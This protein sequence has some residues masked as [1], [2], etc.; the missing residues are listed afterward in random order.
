MKIS[1][2]LSLKCNLGNY[3]VADFFVSVEEDNTNDGTGRS[4]DQFGQSLHEFCKQQLTKDVN[5]SKKYLQD[6]AN[7]KNYDINPKNNDVTVV[8]NELPE[9]LRTK[10]KP[11]FNAINSINQAQEFVASEINKLYTDPASEFADGTWD[12]PETRRNDKK[13]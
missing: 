11:N 4:L 1:K 12:V 10:F 3:Q 5:N 13:V 2:S 6:L 8:F 9:H 7:G